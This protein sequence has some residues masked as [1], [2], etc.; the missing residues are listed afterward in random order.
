LPVSVRGNAS[1]ATNSRE[2]REA[3]GAPR[4]EAVRNVCPL[5]V[6]EIEDGEVGLFFAERVCVDAKS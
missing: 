2:A 3:L 6:A 5:G 4:A 1:I